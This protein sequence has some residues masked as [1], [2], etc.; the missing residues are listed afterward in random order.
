MLDE[1]PRCRFLKV[2]LV[3]R[4]YGPRLVSE[5]DIFL[6]Q[7]FPHMHIR[8]GGKASLHCFQQHHRREPLESALRVKA[9][10][11]SSDSAPHTETYMG[12]TSR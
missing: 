10:L 5:G 1:Y 4:G 6:N 12:E 2:I 7:F 11:N 3:H 8:V 9:S